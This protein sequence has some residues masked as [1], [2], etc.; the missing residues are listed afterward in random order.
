M[1]E[2]SRAFDILVSVGKRCFDFNREFRRLEKPQ[3]SLLVGRH[4]AR[5][6]DVEPFAIGISHQYLAIPDRESCSIYD[7]PSPVRPRFRPRR[8]S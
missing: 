2:L 6:P 4:Q 1:H 7:M 5:Q 3:R 8:N